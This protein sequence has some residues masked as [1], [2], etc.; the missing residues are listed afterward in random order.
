MAGHAILL[1]LLG[2]VALLL[3]GTHMVRTAILRGFDAEIRAAMARA[4]GGPL[5]AAVTGAAT[6]TALQSATATAM[7]LVSFV[8]RG[9]IAL[10]AALALMLG[11]DLGTTLAVQALSFDLSAVIPV[12][13][14]AGVAISRMSAGLRAG[15]IGRLCIGFALILLALSLIVGASEPLRE[16]PVTSLV[17]SRLERDPI[18]ALILGALFTWLMH[19]S[20]AFVLFVISLTG[21]GVIGLPLALALVLGANAGAGLTPVGLALAAPRAARRVLYG[22]LAFRALGA[23]LLLPVVGALAEPVAALAA[24]PGRA[25]AHFHTLFNL[26]LVA[27]FLPLT[28]AAARLLERVLPDPEPGAETP[29]QLDHLDPGLFD[30]PAL[31]LNAATRATL[32]L[33]DKVELMLREAIRAF[34]GVDP[35]RIEAVRALEDEVDTVQEEIKLYLARLMQSELSA[36]ES[37]QVLEL[38]LLTTN[39]EHMGDIIDKGLM[40]LAAKKQKQGLRFSDAGWADIRSFHELIAEQM[41]RALAVFVSRDPAM[42]RDLVAAKDKLRDEEMRATERHFARLRDGMPETIET[43]ALHLDVLR[44][45]KRINAHLTTVAYPILEQTGELRGSRLRAPKP[46]EE[47]ARQRPAA[48]RGEKQA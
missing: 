19:S 2:G 48:R 8:G 31:A 9:L 28:G 21:A 30:R 34:D 32:A 47:A 26:G 35:R 4:A 12:L 3:W 15:Q 20:V 11:A 39:L 6:A 18:L 16:S 23:L 7:L 36:E 41:R 25:A 37:A 44:D 5:R 10:P 46:G 29:A 43:S 38:V 24:D 22:N 45:L 17:L 27:V 1:N 13:L 40:R 33:A 14:I 42:A